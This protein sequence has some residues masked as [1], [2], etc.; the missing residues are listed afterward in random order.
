MIEEWRSMR[1]LLSKIFGW[2]FVSNRPLHILCVGI[3]SLLLG[4]S[5]GIASIISL[6]Y[7]DVQRGG[8]QCWDWLDCVA[9]LIGC[10][11]GGYLHYNLFKH[12]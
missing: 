4:W 1:E 2:L 5:A 7:K 6:E 8:W 11:I 10:V 12:W 9:G 3:M